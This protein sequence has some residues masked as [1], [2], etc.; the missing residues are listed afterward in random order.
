IEG[1]SFTSN[2]SFDKNI[3]NRKLW[4]IPW[5]LYSWDGQSVDDN[6]IPVLNPVKKGFESPQLT[7]R[8]EDGKRITINGLLNYE[9]SIAEKHRMNILVGSER[10]S[11][12][13]MNFWAFR[14]HF[15]ST[16][17]DQLFAGGELEKDNNGSASLNARLNYFGRVNYDYLSKYLIEFVW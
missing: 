5:T 8:M 9:K 11:G 15:A 10:I 12:D 3:L 4:E 2:V 1:L 13:K 7:Q 14:K 6:N 17:L 16:A